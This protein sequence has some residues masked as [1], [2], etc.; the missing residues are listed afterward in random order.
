M[1]IK[2]KIN[3]MKS[4]FIVDQNLIVDVD[5]VLL[6]KI[7]TIHSEIKEK[8][9]ASVSVSCDNAMH[10]M[11]NDNLGD[12]EPHEISETQLTITNDVIYWGGFIKDSTLEWET[13]KISSRKLFTAHE[14]QINHIS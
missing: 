12:M 4:E 1:L 14:L 13:I 6:D 10:I 3:P 7:N 9:Y 11:D 8:R 2:I 5:P